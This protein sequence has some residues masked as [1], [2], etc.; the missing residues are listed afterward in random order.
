MSPF[1]PFGEV[2]CELE[3]KK[4]G[5]RYSEYYF[6]ETPFTK[7]AMDPDTY[8]I[9]GRRGSG[10]TSLSE[11]FGFQQELANATSIDVNEPGV[12]HAILNQVAQK[13]DQPSELAIPLIKDVWEYAIW[14]L[15]L[16]HIKGHA[17]LDHPSRRGVP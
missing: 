1:H 16:H 7:P 15:V 9:I 4:F 12:Y 10:K 8:L 14:Q 11:Y 6:T 17:G 2:S 13:L 3:K 5:G